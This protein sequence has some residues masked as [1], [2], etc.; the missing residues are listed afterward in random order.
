MMTFAD[1]VKQ[2]KKEKGVTSEYLSSQSGIPAG[3]LAKLLSGFTEEPKLSSAVSIAKALGCSLEYLATGK[4]DAPDFSAEEID[5]IEKY[6]ALDLHG[7]RVCDYIL[8]EEYLRAAAESQKPQSS[9]Y[10]IPQK[11]FTEKA[12]TVTRSIPFYDNRVSAGAGLHL[13]GDSA[14]VIRIPVSEK[15]ADADYALRISGNSMEPRFRDGDIL[16]VRNTNE[17]KKGELG[18]F[19][20]DGEGYFKRFGGDCLISLNPDYAPIPLSSFG[21]FSC[22]GVIVGK[23]QEKH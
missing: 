23:M 1:R 10:K 19:I 13:D 3:T 12:Q 7:K 8:G 18:I 21:D 9:I 16:L 2:M 22:R 20:G 17:I 6:R 15:T 5:L 14:G 11:A 4:P